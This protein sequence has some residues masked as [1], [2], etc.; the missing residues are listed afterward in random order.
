[1][2]I[3]SAYYQITYARNWFSHA[4]HME[5]SNQRKCA[6]VG[7]VCLENAA[8]ALGYDLVRSSKLAPLPDDTEGI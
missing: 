1:M 8:R 7:L 5:G 4:R 2:N 6:D 3:N